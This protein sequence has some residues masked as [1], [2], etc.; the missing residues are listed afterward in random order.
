MINKKN[1]RQ[2]ELMIPSNKYQ[3]LGGPS[4][5]DLDEQK[6]IGQN[7]HPSDSNLEASVKKLIQHFK[8]DKKLP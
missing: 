3:V 5:P 1:I 4:F 8:E 7:L 2:P 6:R